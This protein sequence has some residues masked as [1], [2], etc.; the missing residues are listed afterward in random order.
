[1]PHW[2]AVLSYVMWTGCLTIQKSALKYS[3]WSEKRKLA[4]PLKGTGEIVVLTE[5]E[6]DPSASEQAITESKDVDYSISLY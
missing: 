5:F 3:V 1:M 2:L 4:Q 6:F